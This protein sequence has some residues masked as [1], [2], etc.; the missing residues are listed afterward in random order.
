MTSKNRNDQNA[1]KQR[2][3]LKTLKG[4]QNSLHYI[5]SGMSGS[6]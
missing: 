3:V 2:N 1:Y 6:F 4:I 5:I